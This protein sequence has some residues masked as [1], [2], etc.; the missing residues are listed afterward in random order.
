[1]DDD[2]ETAPLLALDH[3]RDAC[4]VVR[5]DGERSARRSRRSVFRSGSHTASWSRGSP[6]A[7]RSPAS[8]SDTLD[9]SRIWSSEVGDAA[10]G[11]ARPEDVG[12]HEE[13]QGA[14][15]EQAQAHQHL[16]RRVRHRIGREARSHEDERRRAGG[17]DVP[18]A[19]P[20]SRGRCAPVPEEH[21]GDRAEHEGAQDVRRQAECVLGR[22]AVMNEQEIGR[23]RAVALRVPVEEEQAACSRRSPAGSRRPRR[24]ARSRPGAVRTDRRA[25]GGC[26]SRGSA[27]HTAGPIV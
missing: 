14:E 26:P 12:Q 7:R 15:D 25:A 17:Q 4:R 18:K 5:R 16:L 3:R 2:G 21:H 24:A 23:T 8:A 13:R 1:M 20:R 27:S 9:E 19:A 6:S 11:E 22:R 10:A